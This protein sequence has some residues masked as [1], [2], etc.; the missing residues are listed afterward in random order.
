MQHNFDID[1]P[2]DLKKIK[3]YLAK[4]KINFLIRS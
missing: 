2:E 4:I 1:Y 3:R